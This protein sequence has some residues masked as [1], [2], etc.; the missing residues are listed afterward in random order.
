MKR[1]RNWTI[2]GL[3]VVAASVVAS[4]CAG[5]ELKSAEELAN[6]LKSRIGESFEIPTTFSCDVLTAEQRDTKAIVFK[7]GADWNKPESIVWEWAPLEALPENRGKWFAHISE[8]K[9]SEGLDEVLVAASSGGVARIRY[10][11][12]KVLFYGNAGG[13]TH[14]IAKLPDGNVA[15]ASST[16]AYVGLFAVPAENE[17][18]GAKEPTPILKKYELVGAHGVVW[19]AK[20]KILWALGYKYILGFEYVGTKEAPELKEVHR[21]ET[22]GTAGGGHDLYPAPGYD[23]LMTTGAGVNVFDPEN[24]KFY[25]VSPMKRVKSISL[26]PEGVPLMQRA[27][28]EWWSETIFYGDDKD[29]AVGTYSGARFYKARWFAPNDWSDGK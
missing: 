20:R 24:L 4:T 1:T 21:I 29:S 9:P 19:D 2:L 14:S 13:N 15:T 18:E 6:Y 23:A 22:K 28:E 8:V 26:S 3:L 10:S 7:S 25:T 11:D 16:G 27:V 17:T 12:K 5:A